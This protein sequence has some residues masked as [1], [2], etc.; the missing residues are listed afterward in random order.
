MR[1]FRRSVFAWIALLGIVFT[2]LA[3][4]G[5][6]CPSSVPATSELALAVDGISGGPPC[7][8]MAT[9]TWAEFDA[10]QPG[11]CNQHCATDGQTAETRSVAAV[12][13]TFVLAFVLPAPDSFEL[14]GDEH[15]QQP[16]LLRPTA[17]PPLWRSRRLRI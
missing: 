9:R 8:E 3:V 16:E 15:A 14:A 10:Q 5:Y 7:P 17:P 4:A 1:A 13:P 2:Q 12:H 11:L 6:A